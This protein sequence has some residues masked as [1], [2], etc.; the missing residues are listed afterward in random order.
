MLELTVH[1]CPAEGSSERGP[2]MPLQ[3]TSHSQPLSEGSAASEEAG[4]TVD[5]ASVVPV[6][7]ARQQSDSTANVSF[8]DWSVVLEEADVQPDPASFEVLIRDVTSIEAPHV[9]CC[10]RLQ[11]ELV[12]AICAKA[13][14]ERAKAKQARK[15]KGRAKTKLRRRRRSESSA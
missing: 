14:Q 15:A 10:D 7:A 1:R 13:R 2:S 12:Y 5:N 9:A 8:E 3:I 4:Q 6:F 11:N